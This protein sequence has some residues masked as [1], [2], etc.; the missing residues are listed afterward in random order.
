MELKQILQYLE[1]Q[2]IYLSQYKKTSS[3]MQWLLDISVLSAK[4]YQS[5]KA[6]AMRRL[7]LKNQIFQPALCSTEIKRAIRK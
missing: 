7:W 5:L 6:L 3:T 2:E 4:A 1:V